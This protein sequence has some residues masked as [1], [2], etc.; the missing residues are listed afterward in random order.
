M[1]MLLRCPSCQREHPPGTVVCPNDL[2]ELIPAG[3]DP[4][5]DQVIG[6]YRVV[7]RLGV[8]AMGAVYE[9]V[10]QLIDRR[11][12][13]K[14]L[15]LA[16]AENPDLTSLLREAKAV[17][18]IHHP[19]IV[20]IQAFSET[21]EGRQY[22][23]MELLEGELLSARL[24]RGPLHLAEAAEIAIPLLDALEAAHG[25]G[26]VHRD[27][28][29]SNVFLAR[30]PNQELR[31]KLL[32]FG[33]VLPVATKGSFAVGT[34]DYVAPEQAKNERAGPKADLFSFG[35][36]LFEMLTGKLPFGGGTVNEVL[37]RR[38]SGPTSH[39]RDTLP[40]LPRSVDTLIH[41]LL[42]PQPSSRPVSAAAVRDVLKKAVDPGALDV[43]PAPPSRRGVTAVLAAAAVLA[44]TGAA[45]WW[46]RDDGPPPPPPPP[47]EDPAERTARRLDELLSRAGADAGIAEIDA[48]LAAERTYPR[49]GGWSERR[50]T[51]AALLRREGEHAL[52]HGALDTATRA[53]AGLQRLEEPASAQPLAAELARL[54]F[55]AREGMRRI[56]PVLID[57]YEYPNR[58]GG[59]PT[60]KVDHA[61]AVALCTK[62]GKHLCTEQEWEFACAGASHRTFP[63]GNEP[64]RGRC[65]TSGK[66][67][68]GPVP[69]G[70][71][72]GCVTPE[73]V[74][75]LAGNLAEWTDTPYR[76]GAAQRVVRGGSYKQADAATACLA[77]DY[78]LPGL[79][80]RK[81]LGFRCC[82]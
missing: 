8:G 42:Q 44:I 27:L 15:H 65:R 40:S 72:S 24:A 48:L 43:A 57:A 70:S 35:V 22:L 29:P 16:M 52:E 61:D 81:E 23:V 13:L 80:G 18:A 37:Q 67:A 69:S 34:P 71:L 10:D 25:A 74:F 79:G 31:P 50:N 12:A 5:L 45:V 76:E 9:A 59:M 49:F 47:V 75:D 32:D 33:L 46:L 56:G 6:P 4:L 53:I 68:K 58:A 3:V 36:M 54:E 66:K 38:M 2:T 39:V 14:L 82:R 7:R 21:P 28:K 17:N 11:V 41:A 55:G 73:G 77:R 1:S 63:T 30:G 62:A 60:A 19:G 26:L 51:L 64:P 78:L 20:D